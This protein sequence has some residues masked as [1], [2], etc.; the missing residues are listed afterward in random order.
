MFH[1]KRLIKELNTPAALE[2]VIVYHL[3]SRTCKVEIQ[4]LKLIKLC[5]LGP[6]PFVG[7]AYMQKRLLTFIFFSIHVLLHPVPPSPL[8]SLPHGRH[9]PSSLPPYPATSSLYRVPPCSQRQGWRHDGHLPPH[10]D[11]LPSP[12]S[13]GL[14]LP[15]GE[16]RGG[17]GHDSFPPAARSTAAVA[18]SSSRWQDLAGAWWWSGGGVAWCQSCFWDMVVAG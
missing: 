1:M 17:G 7:H 6:Y 18:V 8:L 11:H 12:P 13:R 9:L 16:I 2:L 15:G 5:H 4:H 14:L 3:G 10:P